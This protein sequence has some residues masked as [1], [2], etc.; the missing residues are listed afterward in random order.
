MSIK[1]KSK[2]IKIE[3]ELSHQIE[4]LCNVLHTNFSNKTKELL[5]NWKIDEL[6]RLKDKAPELLKAYKQAVACTPV[7]AK[8]KASTMKTSNT[9]KKP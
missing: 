5:V 2:N 9:P 7:K 3:D 8:A 6:N 4:C 1:L